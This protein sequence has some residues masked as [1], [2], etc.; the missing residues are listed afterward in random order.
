MPCR[1]SS[2]VTCTELALTPR[3]LQP[4]DCIGGAGSQHSVAVVCTQS[5]S[6]AGAA[7]AA[8]AAAADVCRI[9]AAF[10]VY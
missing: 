1:N 9:P 10:S 3:Q 7:G 4:A 6:A 5:A 2:C 8:A